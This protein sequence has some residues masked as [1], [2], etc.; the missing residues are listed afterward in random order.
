MK[1]ILHRS[2]G[3][4][5]VI[6]QMGGGWAIGIAEAGTDAEITGS[7]RVEWVAAG[8]VKVNVTSWG[9]TASSYLAESGGMVGAM[10]ALT[11][12]SVLFSKV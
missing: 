11:R 4:W 3:K 2:H 12:T 9:V 10:R 5:E 1:K 6:A 7:G 8:A